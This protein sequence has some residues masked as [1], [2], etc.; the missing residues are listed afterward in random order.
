MSGRSTLRRFGAGVVLCHTPSLLRISPVCHRSSNRW[1]SVF[2][3]GLASASRGHRQC[4]IAVGIDDRLRRIAVGID[5]R[6][7]Q[8]R[9][10]SQKRRSG[11]VIRARIGNRPKN[12]A[13][14]AGRAAT[15]V[16]AGL[17]TT[18]GINRMRRTRISRRCYRPA[19]RA[20]PH[21]VS[22]SSGGS[23][24]MAS[25]M[26]A[27]ALKRLECRDERLTSPAPQNREEWLHAN[28]LLELP[29]C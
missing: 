3:C 14:F 16:V 25:P 2:W 27:V 11:V 17:T 7:Q 4:R 9:G 24:S 28:S 20:A 29:S 21:R 13:P 23:N 8:L 12:R 10:C 19:R 6:P 22:T 1:N 15:V 5:D 26:R 18:V